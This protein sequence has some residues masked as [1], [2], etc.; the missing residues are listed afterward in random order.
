MK[1]CFELNEQL[2]TMDRELQLNP[3]YIQKVSHS[4]PHLKQPS[5]TRVI[6]QSANLVEFAMYGLSCC[7]SVFQLTET[8]YCR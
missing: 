1:N 8:R 4:L 3:Q 6:A 5:L 7:M 2:L